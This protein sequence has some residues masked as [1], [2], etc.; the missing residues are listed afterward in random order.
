MHFRVAQ[1]GQ[2]LGVLRLIGDFGFELTA[3]LF[4]AALFPVEITQPEVSVRRH[5]RC[6]Y[7]GLKL[8]GGGLGTVG[9]VEHLA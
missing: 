5:G 8:G 3:S 6:F 1:V 9:C 4:V 2:G 7:R